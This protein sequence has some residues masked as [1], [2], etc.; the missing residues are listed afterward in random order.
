[1]D[2]AVDPELVTALVDRQHVQTEFTTRSTGLVIMDE[3]AVALGA[4]EPAMVLE[5][6]RQVRDWGLPVV[7]ISHNMTRVF[8]IADQI[9]VDRLGG[10]RW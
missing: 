9:H 5:L 4:K 8:Q 2:L 7:L 6:I 10:P 3:P 1:M